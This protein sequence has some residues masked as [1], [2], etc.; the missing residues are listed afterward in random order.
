MSRASGALKSDVRCG[1]EFSHVERWGGKEKNAQVQ[2]VQLNQIGGLYHAFS[3]ISPN[4][5]GYQQ[6]N[7]PT[8][9]A[10]SD[11]SLYQ[12]LKL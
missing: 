11:L 3:N 12:E 8:C 10:A 1:E 4:G 9:G 6:I 2:E 5:R 7:R